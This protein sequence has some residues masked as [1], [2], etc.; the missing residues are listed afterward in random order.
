MGNDE[1]RGFKEGRE[2]KT[3]NIATSNKIKDK[4][5]NKMANY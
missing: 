5:I 2:V 1:K 4:E 3:K